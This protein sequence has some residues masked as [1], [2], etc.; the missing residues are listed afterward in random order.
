L[1]RRMQGMTRMLG[2][3]RKASR[4]PVVVETAADIEID[5]ACEDVFAV[6]DLRSPKNRYLGRGW[7]LAP[8]EGEPATML[9]VDP[10]MPDLTFHFIEEARTPNAMLDISTHFGEGVVVGAM[11]HGRGRYTLTPLGDKRCRV[12]LEEASTL[13]PGLGK[14]RLEE[15]RTMLTLAVHDDLA[16]LKALIE[17]GAPAAEKA[18]ALDALFDALEAARSCRAGS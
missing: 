16:R 3:N 10:R 12:E 9:G 1:Q 17:Q 2:R 4:E 18:G 5:A 8:V 13:V 6:L 7:T 14:R 11:M 15:E